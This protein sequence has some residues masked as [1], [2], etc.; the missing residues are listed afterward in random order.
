MD[1]SQPAFFLGVEILVIVCKLTKKIT[2]LLTRF[3]T[4]VNSLL[5]SLWYQSLVSKSSSGSEHGSQI[6]FLAYA[7]GEQLS[8]AW[9][10]AIVPS[11]ILFFYLNLCDIPETEEQKSANR[12]FMSWQLSGRFITLCQRSKGDKMSSLFN[13]LYLVKK[14]FN[15]PKIFSH[16][17]PLKYY[18]IVFTPGFLFWLNKLDV[19]CFHYSL[20]G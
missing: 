10:A 20:A 12:W 9:I 1:V 16:I 8:S 2:L 7:P 3:I 6:T 4:A 15:G 19:L 14:Q 13:T 17:T 11:G 18:S 5:M